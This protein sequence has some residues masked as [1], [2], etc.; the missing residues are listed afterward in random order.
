MPGVNHDVVAREMQLLNLVIEV[1]E[2]P[3]VHVEE[4]GHLGWPVRRELS[5]GPVAG[6]LGMKKRSRA[7]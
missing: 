4:R 2:G 6:E 3:E 5:V 1:G 7:S